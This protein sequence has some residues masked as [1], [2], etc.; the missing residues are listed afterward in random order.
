MHLQ[1]EAPTG[2]EALVWKEGRL[3]GRT[4][5]ARRRIEALPLPFLG[6]WGG[7]RG[8][9]QDHGLRV[10]GEPPFDPLLL[11]GRRERGKAV[12]VASDPG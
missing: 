10:A 7:I 1:T 8:L 12:L 11:E 9:L 6:T 4:V 3:E 5:E 2:L